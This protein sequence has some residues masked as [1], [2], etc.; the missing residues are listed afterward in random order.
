RE[1]FG[2]IAASLALHADG[3]DQEQEIVLADAPVQ[4]D[5]GC[6]HILTK[7]DFLSGYGELRADRITHFLRREPNRA[8]EWVADAQAAHDD[9]KRGRKLGREAVAPRPA[10]DR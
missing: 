7:H 4:V 10:N 6:R 9:V 8:H 3:G 5:D 2:E 1:H